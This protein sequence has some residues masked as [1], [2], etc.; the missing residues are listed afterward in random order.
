M[1]SDIKAVVCSGGGMLGFASIG[2]L[3]SIQKTGALKRC[4]TYAGTSIGSIIAA[5]C[6]LN[7]D[8]RDTVKNHMLEYTFQQHWNILNIDRALGVDSGRGLKQ[9]ILRLFPHKIT[10]QDIY[11]MYSRTLIICA[12]NLSCRSA[13]YFSR[14]THP[15]MD[16]RTALLLSCSVPVL[17]AAPM[18][19]GCRYND[20]CLTDNF[21]VQEAMR[22]CG[23]GYVLGINLVGDSSKCHT[24]DFQTYMSS[25]L[26]ST[27][28][29]HR[30][31][32]DA[33]LLTLH[34]QVPQSIFVN[35]L[36]FQTPFHQRKQLYEWGQE[37]GHEYI[38]SLTKKNN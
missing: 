5:V 25:V 34:L 32:K 22:R 10:F 9:W 8:I 33:R 6:A 4:H 20:G 14:F 13:E 31:V 28:G 16:I 7:R 11:D 30:V 21:P 23:K 37:Q 36:N 38:K 18:Y 29:T 17:F 3:H 15:D 24:V 19:Q 2:A 35:P 1:N 26:E 12:T 27:I